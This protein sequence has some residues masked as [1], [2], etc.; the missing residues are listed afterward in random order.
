MPV[1][2]EPD[3]GSGEDEPT[4]E[5]KALPDVSHV[6]LV[7]RMEEQKDQGSVGGP[8]AFSDAELDTALEDLVESGHV[9]TVSKDGQTVYELTEKGMRFRCA[10]KKA[11]K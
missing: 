7:A 9:K 8:S 11:K 2:P 4:A 5:N 3:V 1:K 6:R 10:N